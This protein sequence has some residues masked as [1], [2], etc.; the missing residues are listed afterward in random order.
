MGKI[1]AFIVIAMFL[2]CCRIEFKPIDTETAVA[3]KQNV[4]RTLTGQSTSTQQGG[5]N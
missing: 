2:G 1:T 4:T 3:Q 5:S